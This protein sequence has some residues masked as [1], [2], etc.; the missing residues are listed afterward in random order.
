M[1][2]LTWQG[3]NLLKVRRVVGVSIDQHLEIFLM[4]M[5]MRNIIMVVD[6]RTLMIMSMIMFMMI[7]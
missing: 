3:A 5:T 4:M 6:K 7:R 1:T 2:N